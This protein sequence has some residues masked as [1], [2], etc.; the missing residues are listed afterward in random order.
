M[1]EAI[2]IKEVGWFDCPGGGQ[3]VVDGTTAYVGHIKGPEATTVIDVSDPKN[4]K[5]ANQ[6][7]CK[8]SGVHSHKVRA[9]DGIML[10]NYEAIGYAGDPDAGFRGGLNIYDLADPHSPEPIHFWECDG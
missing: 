1:S 4:P 3:V 9:Q 5:L 10:T 6:I 2:G 8:H 7:L